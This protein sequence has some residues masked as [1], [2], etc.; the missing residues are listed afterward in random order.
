MTHPCCASRD[1]LK[2]VMLADLRSRIGGILGF[3]RL[4][5]ATVL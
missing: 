3:V 1:P 4:A 5:P 2:G